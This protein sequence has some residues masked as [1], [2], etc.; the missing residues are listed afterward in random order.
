MNRCIT[1]VEYRVNRDEFDD[2]A[3]YSVCKRCISNSIALSDRQDYFVVMSCVLPHLLVTNGVFS[4]SQSLSM[5]FV[6]KILPTTE[7]HLVF[8]NVVGVLFIRP[9]CPSGL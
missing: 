1:H 7:P 8:Q 2:C 9:L 3:G 4:A 6:S 5:L